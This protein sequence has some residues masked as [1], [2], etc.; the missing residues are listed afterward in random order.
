[1]GVYRRRQIGADCNTD[2]DSNRNANQYSDCHLQPDSD[3]D[4]DPNPHGDQDT[5][6]N[7]HHSTYAD[8]YPCSLELWELVNNSL[9]NLAKLPHPLLIHS[10]GTIISDG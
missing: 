8:S 6:A 10:A 4:S 3:L 7:S 9:E 5:I 1:M 2:T